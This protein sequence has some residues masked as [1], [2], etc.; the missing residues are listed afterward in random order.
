METI[1]LSLSSKIANI[2][3]VI[4]IALFVSLVV[5]QQVRREF[6]VILLAQ[7]LGIERMTQ[8]EI[9]NYYDCSY[10]PVGIHA[11][12]L[13]QRVSQIDDVLVT[14]FATRIP[15]QSVNIDVTDSYPRRIII[16][17]NRFAFLN[18]AYMIKTD[19]IISS[20]SEIPNE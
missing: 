20:I 9:V 18:R 10:V 16:R 7:R 2:I 11:S 5:I 3:W 17:Y 1:R 15:F 8:D 14:P 12:E 13:L 19:G 4:F 6:N